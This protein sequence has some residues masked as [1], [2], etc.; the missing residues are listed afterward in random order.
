MADIT[1]LVT[2]LSFLEGPRWRGDALFVSDMH[3]DAVLAVTADGAVSTV[4]E[5]EQ[6]SGLGWLP[7]GTPARGV[8]DGADGDAV[9]RDDAGG[10]R[11]PLGARRARDQRHGRRPPR[12]R[13]RRSV[14]LRPARG[15]SP[16]AVA[17][18][19]GSTPT[20]RCTRPRPSFAW[21][22]AWRSPL[23]TAPWWWP[24]AGASASRRSTSPTTARSRTGACGPTSPT[25]PT[26]CASTPRTACGSPAPI[27]DHVR[28]GGRGRG[29]HRRGRDPRTPRHRLRP[30][31]PRRPH[32]VH[33]HLDHPRRPHRVPRRPHRRHRDHDGDGSPAPNAPDRHF[34][35]PFGA[36]C[37]RRTWTRGAK[38]LWGGVRSRVRRRG[39]VRRAS[40]G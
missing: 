4:V 29:R 21:P 5:V 31:R 24:R 14:R 32:P 6:P 16:V 8:D 19:C 11:R 26:A 12:A 33:A 18:C 39:R 2:G 10:P 22:T 13:L 35:F 36:A 9:R 28:A 15:W 30:R 40:R 7:D 23:T 27:S 17:R 1:P 20:A 3:G 37:P 25:T 38:R 34:V